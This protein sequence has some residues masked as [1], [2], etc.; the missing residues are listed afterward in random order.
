M[1]GWL[2]ADE[3]DHEPAGGRCDA[4]RDDEGQRLPERE[5]EAAAHEGASDRGSAEDVLNALR[6]AEHA[7]GQPV[8]V[9]PTVRRLVHVVRDEEHD[10][11]EGHRPEAGHETHHGQADSHRDEGRE[12]EGAAPA[13]ARPRAVARGPDE[14][15]QHQRNRSLG[16]EHE[17]DQRARGRELVQHRRQVGGHGRDRP[18][19]AEGAEAEHPDQLPDGLVEAHLLRQAARDVELLRHP[20]SSP[21][22]AG[23]PARSRSACCSAG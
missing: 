4:G 9:Q 22:A 13:Q 20:A 16:R 3:P 1:A 18:R 10:E 11:H 23:S 7:G 12:H 5:Q 2:L 15:R 14:R 8:R 21:R 6:A 17:P 19:K